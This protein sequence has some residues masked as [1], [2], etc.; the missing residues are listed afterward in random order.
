VDG[1]LSQL[2]DANKITLAF[3]SPYPLDFEDLTRNL[4][5]LGYSRPTD[6]VMRARMSDAGQPIPLQRLCK[7]ELDVFY[8]EQKGFL[9]IESGRGVDKLQDEIEPFFGKVLSLDT[10]VARPKWFEANFTCRK[11]GTEHPL[12]GPVESTTASKVFTDATD[13]E[14]KDFSRSL[15]SFMGGL[16]DQPLNQIEDWAHVTVGA[17]VP[18]PR[19]YHMNFV[20]RRTSLDPVIKFYKSIPLMIEKLSNHESWRE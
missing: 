4:E 5:G 2:V 17:F 13:L 7:P 20:C 12:T 3:S 19:Y 8:D 18:N 11:L 14:P 6:G 16:P 1:W 15:C 10:V 9:S